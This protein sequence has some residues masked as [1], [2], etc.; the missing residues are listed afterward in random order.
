MQKIKIY[1]IQEWFLVEPEIHIKVPD[2]QSTLYIYPTPTLNSTPRPA[3]AAKFRSKDIH[4][5]ARCARR[6]SRLRTKYKCPDTN[7]K[8]V[9]KAMELLIS[10][11]EYDHI[12]IC[13]IP[14]CSHQEDCLNTLAK[15][16]MSKHQNTI[17]GLV[18]EEALDLYYLICN[19][20]PHV[21]KS[22]VEERNIHQYRK[23]PR[24]QCN[25][26]APYKKLRLEDEAL[27][28][29]FVLKAAYISH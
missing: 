15:H 27:I 24:H 28:V 12:Y 19:N 26:D 23:R 1:D 21:Y 13:P 5:S 3:P 10:H 8:E 14:N 18:S 25:Q 16:I 17:R 20:K 2:S 29:D 11:M 9:F 22:T 4:D 6:S 7:C